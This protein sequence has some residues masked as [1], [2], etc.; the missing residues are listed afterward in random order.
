MKT[1]VK[2]STSSDWSAAEH[3]K[4]DDGPLGRGTWMCRVFPPVTDRCENQKTDK[5]ANFLST[6]RWAFFVCGSGKDE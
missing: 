6:E 2:G 4:Y 3:R 1:R 5:P